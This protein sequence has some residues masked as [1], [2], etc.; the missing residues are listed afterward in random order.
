[1]ERRALLAVGLAWLVLLCGAAIAIGAL[2]GLDSR[3]LLGHSPNVLQPLCAISVAMLAL[4]L[5]A[6]TWPQASF[7]IA[8]AV[9]GTATLAFAE[10]VFATSLGFDWIA[11]ALDPDDAPDERCIA[12]LSAAATGL[13]ALAVSL[14][15]LPGPAL[16]RRMLWARALAGVAALLILFGLVDGLATPPDSLHPIPR[17]APQTA[18]LLLLLTLAIHLRATARPD[19]GA[20]PLLDRA[21]AW[22]ISILFGLVILFWQILERNEWYN[23]WIDTGIAQTLVAENLVTELEQRGFALQRLANR[24]DNYGEPTQ[25]QWER[26][27]ASLQHF[28]NDLH[29][30]TMI[31]PDLT[32]RWRVSVDGTGQEIIGTSVGTEGGR[33]EA[34][35]RARET[36]LPQLTPG[37][38]LRSGGFGIA[39]VAAIYEDERFRGYTSSSIRT[40]GLL[41]VASAAVAG[42]FGV[43]LADQ[44]QLIA[45]S[46]EGLPG[47]SLMLMREHQID[48]LGQQF[49]L[50]VWP[51]PDY[52]AQRRSHLP[53]TVLLLG[54]LVV[55]LLT[56]A[57]LLNRRGLLARQR[58][59]EL[60]NRLAGTL[61][62]INDGFM[63][64]D[65]DWR[66]SYWNGRAAEFTG[67]ASEDVVGRTVREAFPDT[68]LSFTAEHRQ[69]KAE[70][71]T[72]R[73]TQYF[74]HVKRYFEISAY[75]VPDGMAVYF[76]DVTQER[77]RAEQLRLLE[78]AVARQNDIVVISQIP[79]DDP[80]GRPSVIYVNA[81]FTR[82][83]GYEADQMIG[84]ST[85][86]LFGPETQEK[87]LARID[88]A[89]ATASPVR[90]ELLT[91]TRNGAKLWLDLDIVPLMGEG[92]KPSHWVSVARDV[93]ER[94]RYQEALAVSEER[95]RLA[96]RATRD[97]LWDWDLARN[98]V[99]WSEAFTETFGESASEGGNSDPDVWMDRV[100]PE[101]RERSAQNLYGVIERGE[102]RSS[103]E[104]RVRH[105]D[106]HY[107]TVVDHAFVMRDEQ[108]RALRVIGS[109]SDVTEQRDME[110]RIRQSQKM[111]AIGQ[112][113]GGVAHDFNNLLTVILGNAEQLDH[114]LPDRKDLQMLARMSARAAERGSELTGRLLAF[115][116]RQALHPRPTD[117][118][119]LL[120]GIEGLLRRSLT[121]QIE[122]NLSL[123]QGLW[124]AEIDAGQL[125]VAL[126]N[127]TINARD[128]MPGGGRLTIETANSELDAD[129]AHAC[130]EVSPGPYVVVSVSDT[131]TGMPAHVAA[132]AF[133]P[134]FTTKDVGKGS[135]LGLSMV[136]GFVKQSGGHARIYSEPGHGTT[137]R[138]Y[139]PRSVSADAGDQA[140]ERQAEASTGRER[141]LVVEDDRLVRDH[142]VAL[143]VGLGYRV[144]AAENGTEA[145]E[146]L[147]RDGP[148]DLLFTDVVM[149][150]GIDGRQLADAVRTRYPEMKV[151]F[152]SGYAESAIVH[153]GRLDNGVQLLSKPYRRQELAAKLREVLQDAPA[154]I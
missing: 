123:A 142:A 137:V 116:R 31:E 122:L 32:I 133:E 141:I 56:L 148:F 2:I 44:T 41:D 20:A 147:T 139:F 103:M 99:W 109:L 153:H 11:S 124:P 60:A 7:W 87:E 14:T 88:A 54:F 37:L 62:H 82:L 85:S 25:E 70:G 5:L 118:N 107:L 134:F 120:V 34:Y 1:M 4:A 50:T 72:V 89:L 64:L 28:F 151:L 126:L 26:D 24:W 150:G 22:G 73:L 144:T 145:L 39:Y 13:A 63:M 71:R 27:A 135:G 127:L 154:H 92:G 110:T 55:G 121:A 21:S 112:L 9:L 78:N 47:E 45:G 57:A 80:A 61:E 132:R 81:A 130:I 97:V 68:D 17:V 51:E 93:T 96:S 94:R 152:T 91:Y 49:L 106:G 59:E 46:A 138:L 48:V 111:E 77:A 76:R 104:Y 15:A 35:Q 128:A 38:E 79:V 23:R 119:L 98:T 129:F 113:T 42:E 86:I 3:L 95:F 140:P 115:A 143:L 30:I 12:P 83:T 33:A 108:G 10:Y 69:A 16:C 90:A 149:P 19:G 52:I 18:I 66:I 74:P 84:G 117:I 67:Y 40:E 58:A 75:P 29:A 53:R 146:I 102:A 101:D 100:H 131:G 105:A 8:T 65:I 125:E 114:A 36:I 43:M 136:Y 6:Q